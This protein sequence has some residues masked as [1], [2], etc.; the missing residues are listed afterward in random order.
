[1]NKLIDCKVVFG[2]YKEDH[3]SQIIAGYELL[4]Q[5]KK[6][7]LKVEFNPDYIKKKYI[8]S[9]TIEVRINDEYIICYDLA[10]G[11]QSFHNMDNFDSILEN[12]DF[13]FKRSSND[14]ENRTL[15]NKSKIKP[16]GL[17]YPVSCRNNYYDKYHENPENKVQYIKNYYKYL[18]YY[19]RFQSNYFYNKF[20]NTPNKLD[21]NYK[22]L[23]NVRLYNP[24]QIKL[25][26]IQKA[27]P[28]LSEIGA[29]Q[30]FEKWRNDLSLITKQRIE[31]VKTLKDNFE[32]KFIGGVLEDDYSI[33]VAKDLILPNDLYNKNNFMKMI[34]ENY[35]SITSVGLHG[36]IGWKF[37]E[38]VAASRAILTDSL[39]YDLPGNF[40]EN[41]NYLVY[42]NSN[43]LID[44]AKNL[45]ENPNLIHEIE[46][47]NFEYYNHFVRPDKM[48]SN[49]L[50]YLG[51]DI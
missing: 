51:F 44:N 19:K 36:S 29:K 11:Y 30:V 6:I 38:S 4:K 28:T 3:L 50:H 46:K 5:Q 45:I 40:K 18:R 20:E 24:D 41:T 12:I 35:V 7:K 39:Q 31:I 10:D 26:N 27:Y 13:Y 23:Y 43:E 47:N 33:K 32:D 22:L 49:T 17:N 48:I 21:T 2:N 25:F 42:N 34:K 9:A 15:K 8:H 14:F 1:M 37:G 16:L